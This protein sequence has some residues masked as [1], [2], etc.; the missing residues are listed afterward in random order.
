[1]SDERVTIYG[2]P[3][4]S[5][6]GQA[7]QPDLGLLSY[8][9]LSA[10]LAMADAEIHRLK[11]ERIDC[12]EARNAL[13]R[14]R[15]RAEKAEASIVAA[16][17]ALEYV[18]DRVHLAAFQGCYPAPFLTDNGGQGLVPVVKALSDLPQR[19][20]ELLAVVEAANVLDHQSANTVAWN[21]ARF[22]LGEKLEA[23]RIARDADITQG[24]KRG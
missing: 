14:M 9:E 20:V 15:A 22:D 24:V 10:R 7:V 23:L 19:A 2:D 5:V 8:S 17:M 13:G 18:R 21:E 1:M 6:T 3:R 4:T 16:V 12:I 11:K